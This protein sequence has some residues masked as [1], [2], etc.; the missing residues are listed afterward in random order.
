MHRFPQF[1]EILIQTHP[2]DDKYFT[3]Y[4]KHIFFTD[5]HYNH[6]VL[7]GIMKNI[8]QVYIED[9]DWHCTEIDFLDLR[10]KL[11]QYEIYELMTVERYY[12]DL[13]ESE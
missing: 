10:N 11:A 12:F 8:Q 9:K 2:V 4:D 6:D 3:G 13:E 7:V 5:K 1:I